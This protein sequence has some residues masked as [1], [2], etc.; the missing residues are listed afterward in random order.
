MSIWVHTFIEFEC[1]I[2]LLVI[3]FTHR[4]SR[5]GATWLFLVNDIEG[6]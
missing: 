5:C 1:T 3:L 4:L 6:E 2:K